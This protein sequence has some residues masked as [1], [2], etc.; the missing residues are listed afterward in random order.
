M[1]R[2]LTLLLSLILP[3]CAPAAPTKVLP[4]IDVLILNRF[5]PLQ[6]K[7]VGLLTHPAGRSAEGVSTVELMHRAPEVNLVALFGPEHGIYGNEKANQPIDHQIDRE[8][9]LPVHSLYGKYRS[10]TPAMLEG[11]DVMVIDLQDI[12]VRSYTYVSCMRLTL[13]ACIRQGVE[14]IILDRPNPLGGIKVDGPVMEESFRSYVGTFPTPYLHGLTIGELA[15]MALASEGWLNLDAAQRKKARFSVIPM[16]GWK[17]SMT[18]DQ[19]GLEWKATSPGIPSLS[20]VLGYAMTGL[21][22][23][24][25]TFRHGFGTQYPFRLLSHSAATQN[26]LLEALR[27]LNLSGLDFSPA[28]G[29]NARGETIEGIYVQVRDWNALSPTELSFRMMPLACKLEGKN[30]YASATQNSIDMFNK[31][32]GSKAWWEHLSQKGAQAN[33]S[34]FLKQWKAQAAAFRESSKDFW[35]YP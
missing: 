25:N 26:Q 17:R 28:E 2:K 20:A 12:G 8:T 6:G 1:I 32:V 34:P 5:H 10:P 11:L 19:T 24:I 30:P 7:R 4:G 9:G 35:L 27:Q 21:G 33:P 3:L 22:T 29:T 15:R 13:E 16:K 18:W 23:E 31:H 14:V